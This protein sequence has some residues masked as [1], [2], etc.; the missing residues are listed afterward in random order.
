MSWDND[1]FGL[2]VRILDLAVFALAFSWLRIDLAVSSHL[3]IIAV[4][5]SE[6]SKIDPHQVNG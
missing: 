6:F 1:R 4:L 5:F 3:L 2:W